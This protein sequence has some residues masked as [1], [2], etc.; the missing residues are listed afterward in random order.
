MQVSAPLAV[1]CLAVLA[2]G[3]AGAASPDYC[4]VYAKEISKQMLSANKSNLS[5]DRVHDRLYHKCLN[6]DEEPALPAAYAETPLDG[7]G[8]SLADERSIDN[9]S[10]ESIVEEATSESPTVD[11]TAI[12]ESV[13]KRTAAI[14]SKKATTP[15]TR[16][17]QWS[18]SGYA[19]WS[20]E[21]RSWCEEHFPNSFDPESGTV[22]PYDKT[23]REPC[24]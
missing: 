12:D 2:A 21:W 5:A 9:R 11:A 10:M 4:S 18:G 16:Q 23:E 17:G 1:F 7:I 15:A 14:E 19:M 8:G 3:S 22:L 6:M 24:I 13:V 20:P